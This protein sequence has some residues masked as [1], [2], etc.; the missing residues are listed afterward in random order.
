MRRT[1]VNHDRLEVA[2]PQPKP[3]RRTHVAGMG[4]P[5]S[6][7]RPAG[8]LVQDDAEIAERRRIEEAHDAD[9]D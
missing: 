7:T 2:P 6:S 3:R 8:Y 5:D 9:R 1:R 4:A